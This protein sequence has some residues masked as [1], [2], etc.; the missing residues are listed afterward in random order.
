MLSPS[1]RAGIPSDVGTFEFV[2]LAALRVA[3]LMRGS[4][5]KV[6]GGHK[7]TVTARLEVAQGKIVQGSRSR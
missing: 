7:P 1:S 4:R 5:P 3:Q 6:D 2:V